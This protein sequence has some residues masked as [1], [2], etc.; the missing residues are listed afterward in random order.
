MDYVE[1]IAYLVG[2]DV[3]KFTELSLDMA[4]RSSKFSCK[5]FKDNFL[6]SLE[7]YSCGI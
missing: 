2:L 1:S 7:G 3:D 5:A 6:A 4:S